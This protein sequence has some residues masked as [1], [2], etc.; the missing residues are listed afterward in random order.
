MSIPKINIFPNFK[1]AILSVFSL[2]RDL[3]EKIDAVSSNMLLA[4]YYTSV[5]SSLDAVK[6]IR[7][8]AYISVYIHA[9]ISMRQ[10][11]LK[12]FNLFSLRVNTQFYGKY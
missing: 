12:S 2:F 7:I 8:S 11:C 9:Y 3:Y 6:I 10:N 1:I 4:L 5:I